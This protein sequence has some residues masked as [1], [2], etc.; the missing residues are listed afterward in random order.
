MSS[1]K[2]QSY[3]RNDPPTRDGLHTSEF[4][5]F[6]VMDTDKSNWELLFLYEGMKK[7]SCFVY[8]DKYGLEM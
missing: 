7:R 8:C 3:A 2:K 1:E 4:A 5:I 6:Y